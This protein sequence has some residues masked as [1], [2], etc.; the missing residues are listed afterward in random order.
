LSVPLVLALAASAPAI[1]IDISEAEC[2]IT[3]VTTFTMNN[4]SAQG[5]QHWVDFEWNATEN[6]FDPVAHGKETIDSWL[7]HA[8]ETAFTNPEAVDAADLD[9]DGDLDVVAVGPMI[10]TIAWWENVDGIGTLWTKRLIDTAFDYAHGVHSA[11]LDGDGDLDVMSVGIWQDQVAWWENVNGDGGSWRKHVIDP[12]FDGACEIHAADVD[13]DDDIDVV[14]ASTTSNDVSCW[15]NDGTGSYWTEI[16]IDTD[17]DDPTEVHCF[18]IDGDGDID[19]LGAAAGDEMISWWENVGGSGTTW[20]EHVITIGYTFVMSSFAADV[21]GD[22]DLDVLGASGVFNEITWWENLGGL[23]IDWTAHVIDADF[24]SPRHVYADDID[25]DGDIDVLAAGKVRNDV[26]WWVNEDGLGTSWT[27]RAIDEEF[28]GPACVITADI[29]D[30]G[31]PDVLSAGYSS[32]SLSWW[33][34]VR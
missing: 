13:N 15:L 11:D 23:G 28:G 8:I 24:Y 5:G 33:E 19:V 27:K 14:A 25:Q 16:P 9:G 6:R 17:F 1:P 12:F 34:A 4:V 29:D 30:D 7:E 2:T 3:G 32:N 10:D 18:D 21:D 31:D 22:G 20:S 26:V